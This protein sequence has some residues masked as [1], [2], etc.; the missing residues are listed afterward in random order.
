[1][2]DQTQL[3]E[4]EVKE[5]KMLALTKRK[6]RLEKELAEIQNKPKKEQMQSLE[7]YFKG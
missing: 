7:D 1:M 4:D 2:I 5:L 6:E 3:T